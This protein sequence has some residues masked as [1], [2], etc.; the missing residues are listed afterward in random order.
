MYI[1]QLEFYRIKLSIFS[2]K[3]QK[4]KIKIIKINPLIKVFQKIKKL[5]KNK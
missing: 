4:K 2:N 3:Y 1:I 5:N